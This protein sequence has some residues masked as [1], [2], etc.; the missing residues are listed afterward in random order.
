MARVPLVRHPWPNG[1]VMSSRPNATEDPTCRVVNG[2]L[3]YLLVGVEKKEIDQA[4]EE[5]DEV[6][7]IN[8]DSESKFEKSDE[9]KKRLSRKED[10]QMSPKELHQKRYKD[11]S[12]LRGTSP[13]LKV[14]STRKSSTCYLSIIKGQ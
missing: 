4:R 5:S 1:Y 11:T 14:R 2:H 9:N 10:F 7:D 6:M 13:S 8:H 3:R 12:K